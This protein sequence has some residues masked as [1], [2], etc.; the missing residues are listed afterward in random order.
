MIDNYKRD[1]EAY[2]LRM[3]F[4]VDGESSDDDK[5]PFNST[6]FLPNAQLFLFSNKKDLYLHYL[7]NSC[8]SEDDWPSWFAPKFDDDGSPLF[9]VRITVM[10]RKYTPPEHTFYGIEIINGEKYSGI[11]GEDFHVSRDIAIEKL[12]GKKIF[13]LSEKES[14]LT[15]RNT[16]Y[17]DFYKNEKF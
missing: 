11:Y 10:T 15:F 14:W 1:N 2:C 8:V 4:H 3:S 12:R 13:D 17:K 6:S 5:I 9:S 16:I 7:N